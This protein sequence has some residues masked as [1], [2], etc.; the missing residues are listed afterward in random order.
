MHH[1]SLDEDRVG[2]LVIKPATKPPTHAPRRVTTRSFSEDNR[3]SERPQAFI[4]PPCSRLPNARL[5]IHDWGRRGAVLWEWLRQLLVCT[6]TTAGDHHPVLV[7]IFLFG[8]PPAFTPADLSTNQEEASSW[9]ITYGYTWEGDLNKPH[10]EGPYRVTEL[11][12]EKSYGNVYPS[13][14]IDKSISNLLCST[15][16]LTSISLYL[17]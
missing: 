11:N 2:T 16:H 15:K 6:S 9:L 1:Y 17:S 8:R 3:D 4:K 10:T 13:D 7:F 12:R 14:I 5:K